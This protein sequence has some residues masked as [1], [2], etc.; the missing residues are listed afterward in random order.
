SSVFT[1]LGTEANTICRCAAICLPVG[2]SP[3]RTCIPWSRPEMSESVASSSCLY[4]LGYTLY[5]L[6]FGRR[7]CPLA[8]V[9]NGAFGE[10][11]CW[12]GD[13]FHAPRRPVVLVEMPDDKSKEDREWS[14]ATEN[15]SL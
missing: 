6:P 7:T 3:L 10:S 9:R 12:K 8:G 15:R 4:S 13:F 14:P 5:G 1:I 2:G 11:E